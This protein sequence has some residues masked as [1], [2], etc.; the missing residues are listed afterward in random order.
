MSYHNQPGYMARAVIAW[1][2]FNAIL[3]LTVGAIVWVL[4]DYRSSW[5]V[6]ILVVV[7]SM[8]CVFPSPRS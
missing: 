8:V 5:T 6:Q 2:I 1:C 7:R 3:L 4:G